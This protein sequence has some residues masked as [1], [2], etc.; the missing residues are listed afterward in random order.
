MTNLFSN[1]IDRI[2]FLLP[3]SFEKEHWKLS[4]KMYRAKL[5]RDT[6]EKGEG[7]GKGDENPSFN[8]ICTLQSKSDENESSFYLIN[9]DK[10]V[11]SD[12]FFDLIIGKLNLMYSM[13][14]SYSIEGIKW[15]HNET[16]RDLL[17]C[18]TI[19]SGGEAVNIL[20]EI[21]EEDLNEKVFPDYFSGKSG[22]IK[23]IEQN[24]ME[25][26]EG[27]DEGKYFDIIVKTVKLNLKKM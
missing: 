26:S 21:Y 4:G 23:F 24:L 25:S 12:Q 16:K 18:S 9:G 6:S 8:S 27:K 17:K 1:F 13:R 3:F 22:K 7:E 10:I 5:A 15:K 2:D 11:K 20:I 14:Q 19:Y